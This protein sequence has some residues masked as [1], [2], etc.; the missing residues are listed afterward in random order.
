[1][2][3]IQKQNHKYI[4]FVDLQNQLV[5]IA[6]PYCVGLVKLH[7]EQKKRY[8]YEIDNNLQLQASEK[9]PSILNRFSFVSP[10]DQNIGNFSL[11]INN[12]PVNIKSI[13]DRYLNFYNRDIYN[14]KLEVFKVN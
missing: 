5:S 8:F 9:G 11:F 2:H 6:D 10:T 13:D 3:L 1:M 12:Q 14:A 4:H 7:N